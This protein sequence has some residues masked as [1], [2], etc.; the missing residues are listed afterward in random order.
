MIEKLSLKIV[1][2]LIEQSIIVDEDQD[3]Y[4]YGFFIL[5]SHI[6]HF[7]TIIIFGIIFNVILESIIY[8]IAFRFIRNYAGGYH[9]ST[10]T[11]CE[12]LSTLSMFACVVLIKSSKTY[13]FQ[14]AL[15]IISAISTVCILSIC[16]LDTPQKPLSHTEFNYFRKVSWLILF[17]IV[18]AII[19]SYVFK[20]Q[21]VLVPC[22]LSLI[23]ESILLIV[24]KIKQLSH[25][26]NIKT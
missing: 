20:I 22:C 9:A 8:Y 17:I 4:I 14:I 12:V 6:L 3:L 11:K 26:N 23:F 5:L 7:I 24:E 25:K 2:L 18:L 10:E 13:N 1:K 21:I 19:V 16:P 15:I